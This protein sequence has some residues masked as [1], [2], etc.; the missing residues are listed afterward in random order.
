[1]HIRELTNFARV[2]DERLKVI[3]K[4]APPDPHPEDSWC[5][6]EIRLEE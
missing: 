1:M 2:I 5:E 4:Y 6:W 3:C